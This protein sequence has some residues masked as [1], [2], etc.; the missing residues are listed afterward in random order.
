AT[1]VLGAL[2][3]APA[4]AQQPR[5]DDDGHDQGATTLGAVTVTARKRDERQLDVPIAMAAVTGE[6]IRERGLL[7]V[8]DVLN[9]TPGAASIDGGG[10][11]TQVQIR[12]VS[13]SLG[14]NDNGYYIAD[15]PFTGV[16]VPWYPDTRSFDIDRVEVL[17]GPQGTLF[18]E[19]S[20]GGTV[21]VI[22]NKPQFNEFRAGLEIDA[23]TV[24]KGGD[25]HGA[26][27]YVNVPLV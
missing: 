5:A 7:N 8:T 26:K 22:T 15:T 27:A 1:A 21:R 19:G 16:T 11:F 18:G 25:G 20:M 6:D 12:G 2:L 24:D 10:S 17:K 13:S 4:L 9:I 3:S 14:G 23:S